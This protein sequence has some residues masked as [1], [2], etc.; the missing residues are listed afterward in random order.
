MN[1][2]KLGINQIKKDKKILL[3]SLLL[4]F[5]ATLVFGVVATAQYSDKI[6]G[7]I[8]SS[9]IRFHCLANSNST[10]DQALKLAVRDRVL[11]EIKPMVSKSESKAETV[12]ILRNSINQMRQAALETIKENGKDYDIRISLENCSFPMKKYGDTVFPAGDYDA[13]RVEIGDANGKNFW[14]VVY[15]PLCFV[16]E[17]CEKLDNGTKEELKNIL[18]QEEY[19]I[20]LAAENDQEIVPEIKF[21]IVE[22]W[23]ERKTK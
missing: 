11:A 4:A 2:I 18:T 3:L 19:S 6:Q 16:D 12:E 17:G 15:P 21:K 5:I 10:E 23:Q 14:C 8:S 7:G 1:I 20:I 22:W 9:V 13:L